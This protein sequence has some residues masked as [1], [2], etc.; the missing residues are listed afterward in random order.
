MRLPVVLFAA[1]LKCFYTFTDVW[2]HCVLPE[3]QFGVSGSHVVKVLSE[4][5]QR[6]SYSNTT[7]TFSG[8]N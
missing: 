4:S 5:T 2:W 8:V 3:N 1:S 7:S 6:V